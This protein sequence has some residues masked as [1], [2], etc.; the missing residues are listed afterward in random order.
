[1]FGRTQT[2][3]VFTLVLIAGLIGF[4]APAGSLTSDLLATD[5][6]WKLFISSN[7]TPVQSAILPLG[8]EFV[9]DTE[10]AVPGSDELLAALNGICFNLGST[11]VT[12]KLTIH[13]TLNVRG[14]S[15]SPV[16][17]FNCFF[18]MDVE[19][20]VDG[21]KTDSTPF[22][23]VMTI[24]AGSLDAFHSDRDEMGFAYYLGGAVSTDGIKTD[25]L[26]KGLVVRITDAAQVIGGRRSDLGIPASVGYS[27]WYKIKKLFE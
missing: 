24:P 7:N 12:G 8:E 22:T 26:A 17:G 15:F 27:T 5:I 9:L 23:L 3:I 18:N 21:R 16:P 19:T 13:L 20:F 25:D 6:E 4:T 11:M 2:L 10:T 1:M 14:N